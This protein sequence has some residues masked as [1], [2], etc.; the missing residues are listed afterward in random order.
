MHFPIEAGLSEALIAIHN[1]PPPFGLDEVF[2]AADA[3]LDRERLTS[4]AEPPRLSESGEHCTEN[5]LAGIAL[6]ASHQLSVA[7]SYTLTPAHREQLIVSVVDRAISFESASPEAVGGA[8]FFISSFSMS[9]QAGLTDAVSEVRQTM[10]DA[11]LVDGAAALIAALSDQ[12]AH[13][14]GLTAATVNREFRSNASGLFSSQPSGRRPR[15][16]SR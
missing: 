10:S 11:R 12:V 4:R 1:S 15:R 16:A 8:A 9:G 13:A 2:D 5:L 7:L 6:V 3:L 14:M